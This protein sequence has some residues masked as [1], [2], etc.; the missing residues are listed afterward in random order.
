MTYV[1]PIFN[2]IL[3]NPQIKG[4]W[5]ILVYPMNALINSQEE[6]LNKFLSQVPNTP[7]RVAKY[8]G[9]ESLTQK[10]DIQNN[11]P[12]I[13]LTNYVMLELMLTRMHEKTL[14]ESPPT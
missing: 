5:A 9:Q 1:A 11:P 6:E 10:T 4:V 7:I 2:D 8:T 14:I 3:K 13:L 12:Q